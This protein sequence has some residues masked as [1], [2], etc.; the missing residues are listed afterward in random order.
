MTYEVIIKLLDQTEYKGIF[1]LQNSKIY[2]RSLID[3]DEYE[4]MFWQLIKKGYTTVEQDGSEYSITREE[5]G[6]S[7][8]AIFAK[9]QQDGLNLLYT[10]TEVAVFS[11]VADGDDLNPEVIAYLGTGTRFV[12]SAESIYRYVN[13]VDY[14]PKI[15]IRSASYAVDI[16]DIKN[17]DAAL[18]TF[19]EEINREFVDVQRYLTNNAYAKALQNLFD[20]VAV[21]TLKTLSIV[22][23]SRPEPIVLS[24]E[25]IK[26]IKRE[27]KRTLSTS[28][29]ENSVNAKEFMRAFDDKK[30][31]A[32]LDVS[33][34]YHLHFSSEGLYKKTKRLYEEN[35]N[36]RISGSYISKLTIDVSNV[37]E[38]N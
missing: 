7:L 34:V 15:Q 16:Q 38:V 11:L 4:A 24:I 36:I 6:N 33:P 37:A 26:K 23:Q 32:L 9:L 29:F 28:L 30:H 25:A 35:K 3:E 27:F 22:V 21:T 20:M 1:S 14:E 12:Q 5:F 8:E 17:D 2:I 10:Q 13:N 31:R 19:V 18:V